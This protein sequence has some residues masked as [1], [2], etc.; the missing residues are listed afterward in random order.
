M[1]IGFILDHP[2]KQYRVSFFNLLSSKY[3]HE[4]IVF[5]SGNKLEEDRLCFKQQIVEKKNITRGIDYRKG[6][7]L[8]GVEIVICMQNMRLLNLWLIS[9][10]KTREYKL[11][12]WGIGVSS[13][14]GLTSQSSIMKFARNFLMSFAD[15]L[16]F[17]SKYPMKF[18]RPS[19]RKK[20][21]IALNTIDNKSSMDL[22]TS[23]K[24][25]FIFIG[26]LNKRK[27]LRE[28]II[29]F[30]KYLSDNP[31]NIKKFIIIGEGEE[32]KF[33]SDFMT[34]YQLEGNIILAGKIEDHDQKKTYFEKS[35]ASLSLNQAG[36]SVLESFSYGVPFVTKHH[37]ISGGEH[38]N[39]IDNENGFL[40]NN[41]EEFI[42][43]L[44]WFDQN[45]QDAQKLGHNAFKYY[46]NKASMDQMV[47]TFENAINYT[48]G[49]QN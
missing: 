6:I 36:L 24:D 18:V 31:T 40:I 25:S 42:E 34:Y 48:I 47:D 14:K 22:S 2:L 19:F 38:L 39:I 7:D 43:K 1:K 29:A 20:C 8:K 44:K 5:H 15:A 35:I 10:N 45:V 16:I 30:Q 3:N 33:I 26:S 23:L 27:G 21:F 17:Y 28:M 12:Q 46:L 41:I 9:L 13:S 49:K 11:I 37:T 4:I 32:S